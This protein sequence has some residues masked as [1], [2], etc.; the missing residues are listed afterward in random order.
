MFARARHELEL[1]LH[2]L[3]N[4]I[5]ILGRDAAGE[6]NTRACHDGGLKTMGELVEVLVGHAQCHLVLARLVIQHL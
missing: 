6:L 4:G 3:G 5:G 2:F 1:T